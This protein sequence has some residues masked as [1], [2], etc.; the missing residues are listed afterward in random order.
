M[1]NQA[2]MKD[3]RSGYHA[4]RVRLM[5]EQQKSMGLFMESVAALCETASDPI[6]IA[7]AIRETSPPPDTL[8]PLPAPGWD[9]QT[10]GM[11]NL[12]TADTCPKVDMTNPDEITNAGGAVPAM[13]FNHGGNASSGIKK[14]GFNRSGTMSDSAE[15]LNEELAIHVLPFLKEDGTIEGK[16]S[17]FEHLFGAK[18]KKRKDLCLKRMFHCKPLTGHLAK[19]VESNR[20]KLLSASVICMNFFYIIGQS[21]YKF[22]HVGEAD[23]S[24]M[25]VAGYC[26]TAFYTIE[27]GL[28]MVVEGA[29]FWLGPDIGWNIF[30]LG[31]VLVAWVEIL[32]NLLNIQMPNPSFLRILRFFKISRVLRMFTAIRMFKEIR[33]MVDS[34]CGCFSIF[35][36]C[37]C[38]LSIFLCIFSIFFVQGATAYLE[39][40]ED[41]SEEFAEIL[42]EQFG[43][44]SKGMLSLFKCATGGDDWAVFHDSIVE[45]GAMYNILFV[46]FIGSYVLAFFNVITATFCEKAIALAAPTLQELITR[47]LEKE[48]ADAKEL[49]KLMTRLLENDDTGGIRT[50]TAHQFEDFIRNPEVEIYFEVRGLKALSAHKFFKTLCQVH[51]TDR[52]DFATF[53]SACVRLDGQSSTIDMHCNSVRSTYYYGLL[54]SKMRDDHMDFLESSR[55]ITDQIQQMQACFRSQPGQAN[56]L[57]MIQPNHSPAMQPLHENEVHK[58]SLYGNAGAHTNRFNMLPSLPSPRSDGTSLLCL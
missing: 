23:T 10:S 35:S 30:D 11:K 34:L 14:P 2:D 39:T 54:S 22:A 27:I 5:D 33:I 28:L 18:A 7:K 15:Y 46:V 16:P 21:D 4:A 53:V 32:M 31:I 3:F 37:T 41:T 49:V 58:E 47:R 26:F 19:F 36:F 25:I 57:P 12:A 9:A 29:G 17:S 56:H 43:S 24:F 50:L 52:I 20:F 1:L 13:N 51:Q 45:L 48:Y 44:T 6:E 38:L 55:T 8:K 42:R 40:N